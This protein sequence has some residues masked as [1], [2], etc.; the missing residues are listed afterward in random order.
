MLMQ[1][2]NGVTAWFTVVP[3]I[4]VLKDGRPVATDRI[5]V[6]DW[7]RLLVNQAVLGPGYML[8]SV[9]EVSIE[10]D[11]HH[12]ST[13]VKGK[14]AGFNAIQNRLTVQDAQKLGGS[15][16]ENHRQIEQFNLTGRGITYYFDGRPVTLSHINRYLTRADGEVYI[17]LENNYAG[18]QIKMVSIRSGRDELL[19]PDTVL[20]AEG[21]GFTM[22]SN[23]GRIN[24]DAG[25]I[26]RRNGRLVEGHH[27]QGADYVTVSL[28]GHNTAAVVDINPAPATSGVQ[29]IRGLVYSVNQGRSY[30]VQSI[31]SFTGFEWQYAPIQREFTIDVNTLFINEGGG[32][33]S[34]NEFID[35]T[36]DSVVNNLYTVV[37]DG[38]RAVRVIDMP[39]MNESR[40]A[41][42][43]SRMM[44]I[45]G[46]IYEISG[47]T[48]SLR[49]AHFFD[50]R[51][52]WVPVPS[53][54]HN[55]AFNA[56]TGTWENVADRPS[57]SVDIQG[58]SIIIDRNRVIGVNGLRV[59]QQIQAMTL[60]WVANINTGF[61]AQGYI[62]LVEN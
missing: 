55:R 28:N 61:T 20:S 10:G 3:G 9:K 45:R 48:V 36:A 7:A 56:Q 22:L 34:I 59:G 54:V 44:P 15:G 49:D 1:F 42:A 26:V 41:S 2:E 46:T 18:E 8:E 62:V 16:W 60:P 37:V 30:R 27:I 39:F 50:S 38:G 11:G 4:M 53:P 12:I 17:A 40:T 29:I 6:G 25:T 5:E 57:G 24:H 58:N 32:V 43:A 35:Y 31:Q 51:R 52:G 21:G 47:N 23:D 33:T 19:R 14:I 13:I